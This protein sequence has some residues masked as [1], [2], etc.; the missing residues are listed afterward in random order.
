MAEPRA[1]DW[2]PPSTLEER[3]K[4][5][6]VPAGVELARVAARELKKGEPEV[7]LLS[8][9]VDPKR[10]AVDAGANRGVWSYLLSPLVPRVF[11][12][13]PNPKLFAVLKAGARSNVECFPYGLSDSDGAAELMIPGHDGRYSNQGATLNPAKIGGAAH[14]VTRIETRKLDSL[15]LPPVGFIKIDVE[16]HEMAV[17]R[18]A[19]A[20]IA[21]DKPRL[22]VEMEERHTKTPLANAIGEIKAMGYRMMYLGAEGLTDGENFNAQAPPPSPR[23]TPV[24]N[25]I[26][27]PV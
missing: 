18:G 14:A 23:G 8:G 4:R 1:P 17:L 24:N 19:K 6:L 7:R 22:I 13:E 5:L 10:A 25:F 3:V 15:N 21:R 11:A 16:G 26:F 20:L 27:I 9:L 12:Y 2:T